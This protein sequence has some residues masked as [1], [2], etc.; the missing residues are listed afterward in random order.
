MTDGTELCKCACSPFLEHHIPAHKKTSPQ[1]Q[2]LSPEADRTAEDGKSEYRRVCR[3][4]GSSHRAGCSEC[5]STRKEC[6][7]TEHG[8]RRILWSPGPRRAGNL[9]NGRRGRLGGHTAGKPSTGGGTTA[10]ACRR[11]PAG[12]S[13]SSRKRTKGRKR[14]S[15]GKVGSGR[16]GRAIGKCAARKAA[17]S[18]RAPSTGAG[19]IPR[20]WP[21]CF[22]VSTAGS[23]A[24]CT[25]GGRSSSSARKAC[26]KQI[27]PSP[28]STRSIP[29]CGETTRT[30]TSDRPGPNTED[31]LLRGISPN[32]DEG[33]K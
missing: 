3:I 29:R 27:Y 20:R 30:G 26:R 1:N 11:G 21:A 22:P 13:R 12:G 32:I 33:H 9:R 18:R 28:P 16:C 7:S 10:W 25:G 2:A 5:P 6:S 19:P 15:R 23:S 8:R 17:S 14:E 24:R 31:M 4:S